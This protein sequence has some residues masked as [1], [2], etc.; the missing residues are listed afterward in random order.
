MS[1]DLKV[2]RRKFVTIRV[3]TEEKNKIEEIA[4][5]N[6]QDVSTYVRKLVLAQGSEQ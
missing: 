2:H 1:Q 6:N 4:K 3:T 5:T